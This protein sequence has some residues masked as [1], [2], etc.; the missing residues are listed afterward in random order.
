MLDAI[1]GSFVRFPVA[2]SHEVGHVHLHLVGKISERLED[3]AF[4]GSDCG[5]EIESKKWWE[6]NG[7]RPPDRNL[8]TDKLRRGD[9]PQNT[10]RP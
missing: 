5:S 2:L 10:V 4:C 7:P 1:F 3:L 9:W 6:N 8:A